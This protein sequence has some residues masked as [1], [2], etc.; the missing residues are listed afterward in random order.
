MRLCCNGLVLSGIL[1]LGIVISVVLWE[2]SGFL[3][4]HVGRTDKAT[5]CNNR[6]KEN[7]SEQCSVLSS[8][9]RGSVLPVLGGSRSV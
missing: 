2:R 5:M 8:L 7:Q 3:E 4:A 6:G 9:N 1:E